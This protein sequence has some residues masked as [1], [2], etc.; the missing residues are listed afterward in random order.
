MNYINNELFIRN[1][2]EETDLDA[3]LNLDMKDL[4]ALELLNMS[5]MTPKE[6]MSWHLS[7]VGDKT[8][9]VM[10]EG[11]I[12]GILGI[13][14]DENILWFTTSH[15]SRKAEFS[16][17]RDFDRVLLELMQDANVKYTYC[18]V[19]ATYTKSVEW[20]IKGGFKIE[21]EVFIN[22]NKFYIMRYDLKEH[23]DKLSLR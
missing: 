13:D 16:L 3:V 8:N 6:Y 19:D 12:V 9:V 11:K 15:L 21:K 10:Y 23:S 2:N 18:Y 20:S 7:E 17:V 14:V 4:D 5:N 22:N 1:Y